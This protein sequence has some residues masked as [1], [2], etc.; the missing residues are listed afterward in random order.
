MEFPSFKND[1]LPVAKRVTSLVL[2]YFCDTY[3][4]LPCAKDFSEMFLGTAL[5]NIQTNSWTQYGVASRKHYPKYC[6]CQRPAFWVVFP[7]FWFFY[8]VF[9]LFQDGTLLIFETCCKSF[10][11]KPPKRFCYFLSGLYLVGFRI[12]CIINSCN[13]DSSKF[14]MMFISVFC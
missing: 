8:A 5:L 13:L 3:M 1:L 4:T 2:V 7:N 14:A 6:L 9:L 11:R 12:I 10:S